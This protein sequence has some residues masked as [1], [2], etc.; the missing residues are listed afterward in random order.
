MS[1]A[2]QNQRMELGVGHGSR[3]SGL[4]YVEASRARVSQSDL[5]TSE[6]ATICGVLCIIV[7]ITWS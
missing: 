4:L 6:G 3:P 5:K 2:P 7:E 1:V